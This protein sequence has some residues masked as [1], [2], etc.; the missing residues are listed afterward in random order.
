MMKLALNQPRFD[1]EP[2]ARMKAANVARI[3]S[4]MSD[5]DWI[6]ARITNSVA[7]AGHPYSGNA[8]GTISGLNA[9]TAGDL[10][11]F[12]KTR[13]GRDRLL[14]SAVGDIT[15]DE[16][17]TRLDEMFGALPAKAATTPVADGTVK[18]GG[19]ITLYKKDIPQTILSIVQP[20]L[21]VRDPDYTAA[22]LMNFILG[23]SG[24]GSRLMDE[25]REK[26][27]LTYGIY[28]G[29]SHLE[30]METLNVSSSFKNENT[31]QV[32]E[33]TKQG[34]TK[35]RTQPVS[36]KELSSAKAYLTG[37]MPLS[38]SSTGSIAG[39]LVGMQFYG[40]PIDYLDKRSA[41]INAVTVKDV[42]RVAQRILQPD[43]LT[44]ILVGSPVD[45]KPD[46]TV[47]TIPDV[48]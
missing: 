42:Q 7:F 48:E 26:R 35:L 25:V 39:L 4:S 5:P 32:L 29:F 13:L 1:A 10:K 20:G 9:I 23:G 11:Q 37:S 2:L 28:S 34:W 38:L 33:L 19:T 21:A 40:R 46:R 8:G 27:G 12:A 15:P 41:L 17:K 16:L 18:G 30:H 31:K 45:V 43:N 22:E 14:V 3:K 6:A 24:F 47:D 44:V 36:D